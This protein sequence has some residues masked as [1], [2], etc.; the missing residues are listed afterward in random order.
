MVVVPGQASND[1][2]SVEPKVNGYS[3]T[4]TRPIFDGDLL[5]LAWE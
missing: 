5:A 2:C 4:E 3:N 1:A